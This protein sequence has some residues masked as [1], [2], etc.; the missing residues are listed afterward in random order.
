[1]KK[2]IRLGHTLS[3]YDVI[4]T[5]GVLQDISV[6]TADLFA[7]LE[8]VAN[9]TK[10]PVILVSDESLFSPVLDMLEHLTGDLAAKPFILPYFNPIAPL[11][12][13]RGTIDKMFVSIERG[14]QPLLLPLISWPN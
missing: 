10:P 13:N 3:N 7:T 11:V 4:S 6:R 5:L 14:I 12:V 9:T 2:M 1:M 8:M